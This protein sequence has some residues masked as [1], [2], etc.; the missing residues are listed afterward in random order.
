M[1]NFRFRLEKVLAWR[2][3]QVDLEEAKFQQR[4]LELREVENEQARI[5]AAGNRAETEVRGWSPLTGYDLETLAHYRKYVTSQ[6]KQIAQRR[7][8]ARQR[9]EAQQ[10][11]VFEARRRCQLLERLRDRRRAEWQAQAGKELEELAAESYLSSLAR[12]YG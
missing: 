10:Q 6:E 9:L 7:E 4:T 12:D 8:E 11:A 1:T 5:E 3:T 2:R